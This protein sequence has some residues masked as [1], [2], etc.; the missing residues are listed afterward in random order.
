M[1]RKMVLGWFALGSRVTQTGSRVT[2]FGSRVKSIGARFSATSRPGLSPFGPRRR[3]FTLI[4]LLIVVGI[5]SIASVAVFGLINGLGQARQRTED[6]LAAQ[7]QVN[8]AMARWRTDVALA[9]RASLDP[10]GT[11][12]TLWH[13]RP[14][15]GEL[16]VAYALSP[17]GALTRT[18][19]AAPEAAQAAAAPPETLADSC[20]NLKFTPLG[21][22]YRMEWTIERGDGVQTWRW[23]QSLIATPLAPA[24]P[25]TA[26]PAPAQPAPGA[27]APTGPDI[28]IPDIT[29]QAP[30]TVPQEAQS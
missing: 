23:P 3:A 28:K 22:G 4:E 15:G 9:T 26:Q 24:A 17:A 20:R 27:P 12:M 29:P 10:A 21:R 14:E 2:A 16:A 1:K 19:S 7:I 11:A 5:M 25:G 8:A 6:R 18:A 30:A 13:A